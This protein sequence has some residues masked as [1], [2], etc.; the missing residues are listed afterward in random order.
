M[1]LSH[2][3]PSNQIDL[4]LIGS[5]QCRIRCQ[6][7]NLSLKP[8][9]EYLKCGKLSQEISGVP[10]FFPKE[11]KGY[12]NAKF[13]ELDLCWHGYFALLLNLNEWFQLPD[14]L[15]T[16]FVVTIMFLILDLATANYTLHLIIKDSFSH[17]F[18]LLRNSVA[19]WFLPGNEL[20]FLHR[21]HRF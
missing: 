11:L 12:L 21:Y 14:W 9:S 15:I 16:H 10:V 19:R 6:S 8:S 5:I 13:L 1:E 2:Y 17:R 18:V 7:C 20:Y 4:I 3:K